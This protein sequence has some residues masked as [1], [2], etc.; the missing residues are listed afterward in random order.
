MV[1]NHIST[2]SIIINMKIVVIIIFITALLIEVG[3]RV[4]YSYRTNV[5]APSVLSGSINTMP[6]ID[7]YEVKDDEK[8]GHW[9]LRNNFVAPALGL[10][11]SKSELAHRFGALVNEDENVLLSINEL[12]FRGNSI[13]MDSSMFTLLML[14]DSVTFGILRTTYPYEVSRL[15]SKYHQKIQIVNGGVEGYRIR[16]HIFE[17]ARYRE[18]NPDFISIMIGWND[19][20]LVP[21][22][23]SVSEYWL[24]SIWL[25]KI[26][27]HGFMKLW[28]RISSSEHQLLSR[29]LLPNEST[30]DVILAR[31]YGSI[32]LDLLEVL[33]DKLHDKDRKIALITLPG[34]F[35]LNQN[36]TSEVVRIGYLPWYTNNPFVLAAVTENY[37]DKLRKF[38]LEK[39]LILIDVAKWSEIELQPR[40]QFFNDPI[41]LNQDG[42]VK[43]AK[44]IESYLIEHE[45]VNK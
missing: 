4:V 32:D 37:N 11:K 9:R 10:T 7:V 36:I 26:A 29:A 28:R 14:G 6:N 24:R 13:T 39:S 16:N 1:N 15:L 41:H 23:G 3:A 22:L 17:V 45:L 8:P 27:F 18:L 35:T 19:L 20:F 40:H 21:P 42:L 2:Q 33:V 5:L 44:F 31:E 25:S 43:M 38:A 30:A 34:L 12:G